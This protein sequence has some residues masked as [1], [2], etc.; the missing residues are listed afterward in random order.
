MPEVDAAGL[1][2]R[3]ERLAR[4]AGFDAVGF[5][6]VEPLAEGELLAEWLALGYHAS[7]EWMRRH[8][9]TCRDPRELLPGARAVVCVA[10]N[11]F[12]PGE[13]APGGL[14]GRISRYAWGADYH[15]VLGERLEALV[16][17]VRREAPGC[18]ARRCV[19][20]SAVLEKV[21]G[22]RAGL[23]WQGK[24]TN[25]ITRQL[26]SWV[27][28]GE[29]LTDLDLVPGPLAPP[30]RDHCGRC[31]RCI[32]AC[33]TR[34]IVAPYVVDSNLCISYLTIEHRG[35]IPIG[36][37]P[38]MGNRIFGCDDCQDVCPWNRFARKA[39]GGEFLAR[40]GNH[41]PDL[42][43]LSRLSDAEFKQRFRGSA[44]L[45]AKRAGFVRNVVVALGNSGDPA[46]VPALVRALADPDA[47]VRGHA[48]WA[49]GRL[50]GEEARSALFAR[51]ALE[52]DPVASTELRLALQSACQATVEGSNGASAARLRPFVVP[53]SGGSNGESAIDSA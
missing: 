26:G 37:R 47:V 30:H 15:R 52:A 40:P 29:L 28:L 12:T 1:R 35:P 50:G 11:Y 8:L 46:A 31:V 22:A 39:E 33:P 19:D 36:L 25:L 53:P 24:H 6:P 48:A 3:L 23:G 32:D 49:L 10:K 45:R 7:M 44:I 9:A 38:L 14:T 42:L 21:W 51:A 34:A 16:D 41:L 17:A 27:F 2:A 5:C 4:E 18:S 20:T 43:E 13:H